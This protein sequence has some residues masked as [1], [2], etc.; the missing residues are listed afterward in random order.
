M[1]YIA[2][3]LN[4]LQVEKRYSAL[5]IRAYGDDLRAF[6]DYI[7]RDN[8]AQT[9]PD[10]AEFRDIRSYIMT[11]VEAGNAARTVNR[12][13]SSLKS[14]F[15]YLLRLQVITQ[16]PTQKLHTLK[17]KSRLP[18]FV[19]PKQMEQLTHIS[20]EYNDDYIAQRNALIILLLYTTGIRRA[21]LASLTRSN[22][23]LAQ[24]T[25]KV[26]GKGGKERLI[27][28]TEEVSKKMEQFL[29]KIC[30]I[31]N[32]FVFLTLR[33][34]PMSVDDIYRVVRK[35]LTEAGVQGK[36]SPHVLRH[37][38]ATALLSEQASLRSIQ[39]LLGH[40]SISSTQIYTHNTIERLKESYV[41]A[42]PRA[43][44]K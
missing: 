38:F 11:L 35:T 4:Y 37:T 16:N 9:T 29:Q 31:Q 3:W 19:P 44:K 42:H 7:A 12:H 30:E 24:G 23:D 2:L 8:S 10:K 18:D 26:M 41:K 15:K 22:I 43:I 33:N 28:L 6:A 36:R 34:R 27:P 32:N 14:F 25:I 5:T 39:E 17:I 21:E 40:A 1:D 13:I 20:L